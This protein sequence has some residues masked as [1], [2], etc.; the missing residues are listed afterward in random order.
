M[1]IRSSCSDRKNFERPG[2]PW[3]PERPLSWLSMRRQFMALGGEHVEAAG[4]DRLFLQALHVL[5]D[6]LLLRVALGAFR[7]VGKLLGDAHVG[8]AAELDVGA[9]AGHVG[10]DGD[11]AGLAG[12]RD[13][14]RL[15]LVMAG[16][17]H[18]EILEAFLAQ[19]LGELLGFFDR[20]G[21]DQDRLALLVGLADLAHDRLVFLLDGPVDLVVLVEAA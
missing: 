13:D 10:G 9:A 14:R 11:G 3:R 4:G 7:H 17:E 2:S 21:A 18:L 5:A 6:R 19:P 8:I 16:V 1:R 12:L 15:A 20:G